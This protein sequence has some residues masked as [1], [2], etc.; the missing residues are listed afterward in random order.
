MDRAAVRLKRIQ[1]LTRDLVRLLRE[2]DPVGPIARG[3]PI[4]RFPDV[5]RALGRLTRAQSRSEVQKVVHIVF[6]KLFGEVAGPADHYNALASSIWAVLER[7]R[8]EIR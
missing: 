6:T 4:D 7:H 2:A 1:L 8:K 3:T 5:R